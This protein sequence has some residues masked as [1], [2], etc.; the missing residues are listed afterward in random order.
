M[1]EL[2]PSERTLFTTSSAIV[3]GLG[4]ALAYYSLCIE[5]YRVQLTFP[6]IVAPN[7][8]EA[9]EGATILLLTDPHVSDYGKRESLA[10]SILQE[11]V[12]SYPAPDLMVWGGDYLLGTDSVIPAMRFVKDASSLFPHTPQYAI[13]GNA[14][15]KFGIAQ[16]R[17]LHQ[18]M[19]AMGLR[20]LINAWEPLVIRGESINIIG[21][22]DP[23]YGHADLVEAMRGASVGE[24]FTLLLSHSPQL[25][26]QAARLG[27]D[28]MLSGHTHGGQVRLPVI[29]PLKTQNPLSRRVDQGYF[30]R[31]RMQ[32]ALGFDPGGD[33]A[34]FISRGLGSANVPRI[35][36]LT[37]RFLCLPE[38]ALLTLSRRHSSSSAP[39]WR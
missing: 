2:M 29:G 19:R 23:Y 9:L 16:Q 1:R 39:D 18:Q 30:D 37:P 13:L 28:L 21:V 8:P 17:T 3:A 14:E 31:A 10:L 35:R 33:M 12:Q 20:L 7:L 11:M 4:V 22:D 26:V 34:T 38:I 15:H 24:T 27:I 32:K 5:P 6:T 25:A 36:S